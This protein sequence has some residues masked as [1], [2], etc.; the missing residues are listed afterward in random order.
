MRNA[1]ARVTPDSLRSLVLAVHL[2]GITRIAVIPHTRCKMTQATDA[3]LRDEIAQRAGASTDGWDF[4]AIADPP[5]VLAADIEILRSCP[6]IPERVA[7]V[8]FTY[9]VD[10]GR[11][12]SPVLP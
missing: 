4:M 7:I 11:L 12:L 5:A 10:S 2:L 9:D 3:E 1:G 6:L 8:G